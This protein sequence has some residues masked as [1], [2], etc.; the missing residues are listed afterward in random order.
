MKSRR[1]A[2]QEGALSV[3]REF[4]A[5]LE[6]V[7]EEVDERNRRRE[8]RGEKRFSAFNPRLLETSVSI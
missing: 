6:R 7:S 4:Q 5:E 2:S 3:V 1:T 8:R